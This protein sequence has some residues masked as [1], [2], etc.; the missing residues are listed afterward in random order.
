VLADFI[1]WVL[2]DGQKFVKE[3]GYIALQKE[4]LETEKKKLE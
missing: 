4:K 1:R 3:A 2:T